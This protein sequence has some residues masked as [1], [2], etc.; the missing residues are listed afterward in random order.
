[1]PGHWCGC[2]SL[3][4]FLFRMSGAIHAPDLVIRVCEII[5]YEC[6]IQVINLATK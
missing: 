5:F 1:M 4:D 2:E 6:R 3:P